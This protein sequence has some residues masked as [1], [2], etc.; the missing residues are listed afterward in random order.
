MDLRGLLLFLEDALQMERYALGDSLVHRLDARVKLLINL[1]IILTAVAV[2]SLLS[3]ALLLALVGLLAVV[4]R[5]PARRFLLS[6][7]LLP[8]LSAIIGLPFLFLLP[9]KPVFALSLGDTVL[10]A[11][12]Q[13]A[14][15]LASFAFRVWVCV[16]STALL[17]LTTRFSSILDALRRLKAPSFFVDAVMMTYRY[18]FLFVEEAYRMVLAREAR[19]PRAESRVQFL[20]SL[21]GLAGALFIRAYERGER[22]YLAMASR[23]YPGPQ[24]PVRE[25]GWRASDAV[26]L[27][28]VVVYCLLIWG[29]ELLRYGGLLG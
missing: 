28:L 26:M 1:A 11:T 25:G 5:A 2:K 4:S 23:G 12:V 21:G 29:A 19:T 22:V 20:T 7:S 14:E 17:G 15:R 24:S 27:M 16:A 9:G 18:L 10:A 3:L 13:G 6:S 8:V